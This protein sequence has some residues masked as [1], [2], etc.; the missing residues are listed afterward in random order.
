MRLAWNL[1]AVAGALAACSAMAEDRPA[2]RVEAIYVRAAQGVLM[3]DRLAPRTAERWA[4]VRLQSR[5]R[6]GTNAAIVRLPRDGCPVTGDLLPLRRADGVPATREFPLGA[7]M[8]VA[9]YVVA[10]VYPGPSGR[11]RALQAAAR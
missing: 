7:K 5:D 6:D 11:A 3:E 4:D 10:T 9:E 8:A 1:A 2:G